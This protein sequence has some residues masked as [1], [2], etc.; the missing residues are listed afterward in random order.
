MQRKKPGNHEHELKYALKIEII[1]KGD[2]IVS[3]VKSLKA[4]GTL[5]L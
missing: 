3:P 2:E 5:L 1:E 4:V